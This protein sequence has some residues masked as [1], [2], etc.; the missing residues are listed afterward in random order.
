MA[1]ERALA[2][3]PLG[4]S[5]QESET[6]L[7]LTEEAREAELP[8]E[9]EVV[10]RNRLVVGSMPSTGACLEH[11]A[12]ADRTRLRFLYHCGP[13]AHQP[14][15]LDLRPA[16]QAAMQGACLNAK[17]LEGVAASLEVALSLRAAAMKP[18]GSSSPATTPATLQQQQQAGHALRFPHLA[19]LALG[20]SAEEHATVAALR[21]C[22]KGA[23]ITD[24]ADPDLAATRAERAANLAS[25]RTLV[26]GLARYLAAKGA[27]ESREPLL[28]RGRFCVAVRSN[29]RSE[30]PKG[31]IKLGASSSGSW[32]RKGHR[33]GARM[34][35]QGAAD[36]QN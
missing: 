12:C 36:G 19:R 32:G 6:L 29:R 14:G 27:A 23:T 20:I 10:I 8:L 16:I 15:I 25:L 5:Q 9:G 2:G 3:L 24:E 18:A 30:L 1:A 26:A 31:S 21:A 7:Q 11:P 35:V 22:I 28:I 13:T 17:Q 33:A 34:Q 4:R